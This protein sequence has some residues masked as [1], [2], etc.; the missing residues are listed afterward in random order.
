MPTLKGKVVQVVDAKSFG[1]P[2]NVNHVSVKDAKIIGDKFFHMLLPAA[3]KRGFEIEKKWD[4]KVYYINVVIP[5]ELRQAFEGNRSLINITIDREDL[6]KSIKECD[7]SAMNPLKGSP[8]HKTSFLLGYLQ[9]IYSG[10][11]D[12]L[13]LMETKLVGKR[14]DQSPKLLK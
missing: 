6:N 12:A 10:V 5:P 4:G 1:L 3:N 8:A 13:Q 7:D 14:A 2:K 9:E 11:I